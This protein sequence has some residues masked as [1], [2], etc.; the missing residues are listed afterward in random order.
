MHLW[1]EQKEKCNLE[2][3]EINELATRVLEQRQMNALVKKV[4]QQLKYNRKTKNI[5]LTEIACDGL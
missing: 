3:V 1:P 2:D 4:E 5:M